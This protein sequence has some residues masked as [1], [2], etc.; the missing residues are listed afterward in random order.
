MEHNRKA[1]VGSYVRHHPGQPENRY[2]DSIDMARLASTTISAVRRDVPCTPF[3]GR[4]D[5]ADS[6]PDR[7]NPNAEFFGIQ[8]TFKDSMVLL[9]HGAKIQFHNWVCVLIKRLCKYQKRGIEVVDAPTI[10]EDFVIE[11]Q[12]VSLM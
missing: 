2:L 3:Y 1:V 7:Y 6:L 8:G 12:N 10:A 9:K 4:L 11:V 5:F